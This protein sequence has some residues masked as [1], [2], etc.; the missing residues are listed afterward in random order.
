MF[1][2][3]KCFICVNKEVLIGFLQSVPE[4]ESRATF[5]DALKE[6]DGNVQPNRLD[7]KV[8]LGLKQL[9]GLH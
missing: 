4:N 1:A 7:P 6:T 5:E 8:S 9:S 3:C 2:K